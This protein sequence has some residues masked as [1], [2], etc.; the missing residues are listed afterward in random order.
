MTK[1][2]ELEQKHNDLVEYLEQ[3]GLV[4]PAQQAAASV[5]MPDYIPFGSEK[6]MRFLGLDLVEDVENAKASGYTVYTSPE[7]KQTYRL[8]DE[9]QAV[10]MY[11]PMD[12]DKAILLVLRQKVGAFESGVPQVPANAPPLFG[13]GRNETIVEIQGVVR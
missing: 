2:Q 8:E 7:T 13:R 3:R 4:D 9:M 6:H 12:P 1:L 10:Q 5:V 11:K